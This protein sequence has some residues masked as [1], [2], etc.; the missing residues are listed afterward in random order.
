M[1]GGDGSSGSTVSDVGALVQRVQQEGVVKSNPSARTSTTTMSQMTGARF[2][3][4]PIHADTKR[5][6][7]EVLRYE[8]MTIVQEQSLPVALTGVDVLAKAKTGT[9]KTLSFLIPA[10]EEALR[11]QGAP[12]KIKVLIVSPTR[13]LASQIYE[14]G[15][16]LCRFHSGLKLMCIYGKRPAAVPL[17]PQH[18]SHP[19]PPSPTRMPR[20][21]MSALHTL[22]SARRI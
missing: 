4:L 11:A 21:S 10:I 19:L 17:L 15:Q 20:V 7:A 18:S 6:L 14:E 16:M 2:A 13:E 5:A 3:D 12:G 1:G 9:G 8:T 22:T